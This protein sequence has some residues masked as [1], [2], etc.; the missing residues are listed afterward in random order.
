[1]VYVHNGIVKELPDLDDDPNTVTIKVTELS[2]YSL[3]YTEKAPANNM[4]DASNS[5]GV[6][7][8]E[9]RTLATM[10]FS[11]LGLMSSSVA[12]VIIIRKQQR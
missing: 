7:N 11:V 3:V 1:M 9:D 6:A 10:A 12:M 4:A 2:T 5:N 8:T